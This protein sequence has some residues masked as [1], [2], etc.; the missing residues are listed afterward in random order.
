MT[1]P[2]LQPFRLYAELGRAII[3]RCQ[4]AWPIEACGLVYGRDELQ[5]YREI[6][7]TL[8]S[9]SEFAMEPTAL[10]A[11]IQ[12]IENLGMALQAVYH[13][14]TRTGNEPSNADVAS[15]AYYPGAVQI[16]V[17]VSRGRFSLATVRPYRYRGR[18]LVP[19]P[20]ILPGSTRVG[21]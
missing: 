12:D 4:T 19:V 16:I 8:Q 6:P 18:R 13:S 14:H 20:L 1:D 9:E 3:D 17:G 5:T 11:A 2:D 21:S 15:A 10:V 7:N